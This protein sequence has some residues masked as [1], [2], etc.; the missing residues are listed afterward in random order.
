MTVRNPDE[1]RELMQES[2]TLTP[3]QWS[4]VSAPMAPAVVIAGAGSGKT[5]VMAA[6][7]I[8]LVANGLVTPDQ[9]LGLTF[10]TK[11]AAE[12]RAKVTKALAV[13][14]FG[15]STDASGTGGGVAL[16]EADEEVFEPTVTTYNAYA[17]GLLKEHGLRIGHEPDDRVMADAGRYQV[18][19]Q[20]VARHR[21]AVNLLSDHPETVI[22]NILALDGQ[23]SEHLV[24]P[25][26]VRM[27]DAKVLAQANHAL[28]SGAKGE[29][30]KLISAIERR[31][32]LLNLVEDYR[33]LK[34]TLGLIDFSDQIALAARLAVEHPEV[35]RLERERFPMVVLDEYQD[36]SVAQALML[37]RLFSGDLP[38]SG[39]GH[40]VT[41]VG[42]PNQ[43]IYG[44]RGASVSNIMNFAETFPAAVGEPVTTF[45]LSVS[46]RSDVRILEVANR[47][48]TP[49]MEERVTVKRL[50]ARPG[51]GVG[52]VQT[53]VHTTY[54]D[55]LEWLAERVQAVHQSE[56]EWREIG[57]LTRDN[58]HAADV[59]DTLSRA[60]IPVEIVGL[61]GLLALPEVS[62]VVA[63]LH[64]LLDLTA[65]AELL[66]LLS[67]PRW[68]IG[69]RDLA[70]L[71]QRARLDLGVPARAAPARIDRRRVSRGGRRCRPRR[72]DRAERCAGRPG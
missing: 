47:L 16:G 29:L 17:A 12:L 67:G 49:L 35:G 61:K 39:R 56:T 25:D 2:F 28:A 7:V 50:A 33:A 66:H 45:P 55:E 70:L 41:A 13:A 32:E 43:A 20:A 34:S 59:F 9:V 48:A 69:P 68:A 6:R 14:G 10:T 54:A 42:D 38:A 62:E 52:D 53:I 60:G 30:G 27:L 72:S 36:T 63:T 21:G 31:V 19:A 44:W 51:A 57:V 46:Q 8:Y 11:A 64:L 1:L 15:R 37:S 40:S 3:Q 5:S 26:A 24:S 71:G 22:A 4:I 23:M 58:A 65:N 18:A